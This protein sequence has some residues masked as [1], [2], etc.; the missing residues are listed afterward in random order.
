MSLND[1]R[2][3]PFATSEELRDGY[4]FPFRAVPFEQIVRIHASSGTTGKRK[5]LCYT[6]KDIDDWKHFFTR[7]YEMAGSRLW[8]SGAD[9]RGLRRLDRGGRLSARLR[10]ARRHG[11]A[12]RPR[13]HRSPVRIFN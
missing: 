10:A 5:I 4:P 13:Q 2:K 11:R 1:L 8:T 6:Q 3:L 7:S 9:R 12:H